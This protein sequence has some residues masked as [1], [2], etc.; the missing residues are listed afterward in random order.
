MFYISE[1][2]WLTC[3]SASAFSLTME[4][5]GL[6]GRGKEFVREAP[7]PELPLR[8]IVSGK[9]VLAGDNDLLNNKKDL[10]W[11]FTW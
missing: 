4:G 10:L 2:Q 8:L 1:I 5:L 7:G 3:N 9:T 6:V 11:T